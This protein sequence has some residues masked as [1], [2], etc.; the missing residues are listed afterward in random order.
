MVLNVVFFL[1]TSDL[2]Q[3][4]M[5]SLEI[6]QYIWLFIIYVHV[7]EKS[8]CSSPVPSSAANSFRGQRSPL[9]PRFPLVGHTQ[10]ALS[11]SW[12]KTPH[13]NCHWW[14]HTNAVVGAHV[15]NQ[16]IF[17]CRVLYNNQKVRKVHKKLRENV[18]L[19]NKVLSLKYKVR[20]RCVYQEGKSMITLQLTPRPR[21]F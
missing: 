2:S 6:E 9:S 7:Q 5:K 4:E 3:W 17:I 16:S 20:S 11:Y 21:D 10:R 18:S 15:V 14:F 12:R 1:C 19:N 8:P 13:R